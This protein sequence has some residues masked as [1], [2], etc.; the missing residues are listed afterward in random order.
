MSI[1]ADVTTG[2]IIPGCIMMLTWD[3]TTGGQG[4]QYHEVSS[5]GACISASLR[6]FHKIPGWIDL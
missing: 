4:S 3:I 2:V 6:M 5:L 1:V